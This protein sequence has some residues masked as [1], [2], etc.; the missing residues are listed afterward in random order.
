MPR[1][2]ESWL[3]EGSSH[4]AWAAAMMKC[5]SAAAYCGADGYCHLEGECFPWTRMLEIRKEIEDLEKRLE[6]LK[7]ELL[8]LEINDFP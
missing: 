4:T 2:I 7:S 1:V 5:Q 8:D 3:G 6:T